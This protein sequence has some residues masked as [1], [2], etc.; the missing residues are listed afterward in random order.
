MKKFLQTCLQIFTVVFPISVFL[1]RDKSAKSIILYLIILGCLVS[2]SVLIAKNYLQAQLA[3]TPI[4]GPSLLESDINA[5]IRSLQ[6]ARIFLKNY[7]EDGLSDPN[8]EQTL[9]DYRAQK[10]GYE[11]ALAQIAQLLKLSV[12]SA[13]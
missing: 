3:R 5:R 4:P 8:V 12:T 1:P 7:R 13:R 10:L 11:E 6:D 2:G 9:Q